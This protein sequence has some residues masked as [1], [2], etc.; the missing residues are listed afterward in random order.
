[1]GGHCGSKGRKDRL[2]GCKKRDGKKKSDRESNEYAHSRTNEFT[3]DISPDEFTNDSA[4]RRSLGYL[5]SIETCS[6]LQKRKYDY[7]LQGNLQSLG[8]KTVM[9]L[10][11]SALF[12]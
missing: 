2:R 4:L 1:M 7:S 10:A 8:L 9:N 5:C 12:L 6:R 3:N 11:K